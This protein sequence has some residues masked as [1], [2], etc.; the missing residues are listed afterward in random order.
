VTDPSIWFP[1]HAHNPQVLC[2]L[3]FKNLPLALLRRYPLS[4]YRSL[5]LSLSRFRSRSRSRSR[6]LSR[7]SSLALCLRNG[8]TARPC[9]FA[10]LSR[11]PPLSC[12]PLSL[13][14]LLLSSSPL[15]VHF[16]LRAQPH[17][18]G[19]GRSKG[20]AACANLETPTVSTRKG[21]GGRQ[22]DIQA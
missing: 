19:C 18:S 22:K 1:F 21:T 8:L 15:L 6:S 7:S 4:R 9:C 10:S 16:L 12:L 11:S 5:S 14:S 3:P 20:V 17:H 2:F 13:P